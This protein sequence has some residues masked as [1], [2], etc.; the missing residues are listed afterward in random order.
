MVEGAKVFSNIEVWSGEPG[1]NE[2]SP[3][4][5]APSTPSPILLLAMQPRSNRASGVFHLLASQDW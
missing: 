5:Q 3:S 1:E 2:A 4:H